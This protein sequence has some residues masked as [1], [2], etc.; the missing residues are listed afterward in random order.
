MDLRERN[1]YTARLGTDVV[2]CYK[3]ELHFALSCATSAGSRK[4]MTTYSS[5]QQ[6]S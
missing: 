6:H 3:T 1:Q 4:A 2:V 5:Q